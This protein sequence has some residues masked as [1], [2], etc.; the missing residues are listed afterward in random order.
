MS[1]PKPGIQGPHRGSQTI[2]LTTSENGQLTSVVNAK[3]KAMKL[4]SREACD[5]AFP[6]RIP[7]L[8]A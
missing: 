1:I 3:I 8:I 6:S 2:D 5:R 7:A 4:V